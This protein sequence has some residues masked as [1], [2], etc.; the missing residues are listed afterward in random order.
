MTPVAKPLTREQIQRIM[1]K[2]VTEVMAESAPSREMTGMEAVGA[3]VLANLKTLIEFLWSGFLIAQFW[4]WFIVPL[5]VVP[6]TLI[7]AI[8]FRLVVKALFLS[9]KGLSK[10]IGN[11]KVDIAGQFKDLALM[12]VIGVVLFGGGAIVHALMPVAP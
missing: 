3:F 12:I 7:G 6:I 8:G 2:A 4:N 10:E 9:S 1:T 11:A 5:G